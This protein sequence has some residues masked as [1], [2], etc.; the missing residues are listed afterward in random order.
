[1]ISISPQ[2][3]NTLVCSYCKWLKA[4]FHHISRL[5][6]FVILVDRLNGLGSG[7]GLTVS[8]GS[9]VGIVSNGGRVL[10][11]AGGEVIGDGRE[12]PAPMSDLARV[13]G[14]V[15]SSLLHEDSELVGVGGSGRMA[16]VMWLFHHDQGV[17]LE[18]GRQYPL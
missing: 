9:S 16:T 3:F 1:M 14:E 18:G 4:D 7:L 8:V 2:V 15:L 13:V 10:H 17:D 6:G 12:V 11:V 5:G